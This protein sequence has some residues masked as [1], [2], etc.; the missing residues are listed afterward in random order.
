[1]RERCER[2]R[3]EQRGAEKKREAC[4]KQRQTDGRNR[5]KGREM[6]SV[7]VCVFVYLMSAYAAYACVCEFLL[8]VCVVC[9]CV[10]CV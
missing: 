7:R 5:E 1:M 3:G 8:W 4:E 10:L 2:S 9:M 6:V